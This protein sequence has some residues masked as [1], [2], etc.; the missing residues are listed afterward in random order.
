MNESYRS[1]QSISPLDFLS[2]LDPSFCI[3]QKTSPQ[4]D[5]KRI[6]RE[7]KDQYKVPGETTNQ[8]SITSQVHNQKKEAL[9]TC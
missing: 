3:V 2:L 6:E 9:K 7:K 4:Q 8:L 1:T 5:F